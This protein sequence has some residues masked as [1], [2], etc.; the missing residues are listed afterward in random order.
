MRVGFYQFSPRFG[1]VKANLKHIAS[2]LEGIKADLF[3]LP[4][5]S[6]S[7]Y[8]FLNQDEVKA[9]A[10]PIPGPTTEFLQQ[11]A[12]TH[13]SHLV[14]GMSERTSDAIYNSAVLVG[15]KGVLGTYR[16]VHLFDEEKHF[17]RP[18]DLGFPLFEVE[19]VKVGIL[20]CF[21]HIFPEAARTLALR[22][23]QVICHPSNLVLP[24]YG[25]L[26]TRVRSIENRVFWVLAN[27]CGLDDRGAKKL[28]FT[29]CSRIT[30]PDGAILTE[31]SAQEVALRVVEIDP[32][33]ALDKHVTGLN[34]LFEDRCP[35]G[36]EI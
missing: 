16:K 21:D 9:V 22:G 27:R 20:I 34:D 13:N 26:T 11:W 8:L 12:R 6:N 28:S 14:L 1:E 29:G 18:G 30:A 19:G 5:L 25:Q 32:A 17:F 2:A 4:E 35:E 10:E 31:A 36:Y 3:V 24:T 23:A 33:Q 15:P 7:G